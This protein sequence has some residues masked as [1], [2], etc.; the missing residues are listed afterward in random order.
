MGFTVNPARRV[1]QHRRGPQKRRSL[2]DQWARA[3]VRKA[4]HC[5]QE[6]DF[7]EKA[8]AGEGR[9]G[10]WVSLWQW[11]GPARGRGRGGSNGGGPIAAEEEPCLSLGLRRRG[12]VGRGLIEVWSVTGSLSE[13]DWVGIEKAWKGEEL[14]R[15]VKHL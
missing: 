12:W 1:Q 10:R 13:Q 11:A 14:R 9:G 6:E 15:A 3:V 2:A 7:K 4:G 8:G 5:E